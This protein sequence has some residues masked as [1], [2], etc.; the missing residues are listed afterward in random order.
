MTAERALKS[1]F[2]SVLRPEKGGFR[3]LDSSQGGFH[4]VESLESAKESSTA[5]SLF[6]KPLIMS[7]ILQNQTAGG[8]RLDSPV[9]MPAASEM[10]RCAPR[11]RMGPGRNHARGGGGASARKG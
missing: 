9:K 1:D 6:S 8:F 11:I 4:K 3:W 10:P 2:G 5:R 7:H